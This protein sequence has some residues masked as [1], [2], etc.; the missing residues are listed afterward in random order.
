MRFDVLE[1]I[2]YPYSAD[3]LTIASSYGERAKYDIY[4][5]LDE[6]SFGITELQ[7]VIHSNSF[8]IAA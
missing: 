3:D 1:L 4:F 7:R 8:L 5:L 2:L 6:D